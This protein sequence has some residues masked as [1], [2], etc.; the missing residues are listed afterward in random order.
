MFGSVYLWLYSEKLMYPEDWRSRLIFHYLL[1]LG[2]T[3]TMMSGDGICVLVVE[4]LFKRIHLDKYHDY[5][6]NKM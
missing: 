5:K 6:V 4:K 2:K 3:Y 1:F